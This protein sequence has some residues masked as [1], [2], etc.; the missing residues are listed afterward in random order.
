[1]LVRFILALCVAMATGGCRNSPPLPPPS[2]GGYSCEESCT[3]F[4]RL[5]CQE[6]LPTAEGATCV[7]I[8]DNAQAGPAP[9]DLGCIVRS[10]D[11]AQARRCE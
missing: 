2:P 5:G 11:C 8:C 1:M 3:A 6:Y 4:A 10:Q 7:E 9:L